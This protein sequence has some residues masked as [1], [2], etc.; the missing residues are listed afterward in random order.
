MG[1]PLAGIVGIV[2]IAGSFVCSLAAMVV[3]LSLETASGTAPG[4]GGQPYVRMLDW[5]PAGKSP[6][7]N[8]WLQVGIHVDSLTIV[9]FTMVTLVATLVFVFSLG[10]MR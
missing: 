5:I 8:G 3:W 2:M 1:S 7:N 6:A 9:M 10:Y 4:A